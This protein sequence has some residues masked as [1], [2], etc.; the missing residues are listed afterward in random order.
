MPR[1]RRIDLLFNFPQTEEVAEEIG[2]AVRSARRSYGLPEVPTRICDPVLS[3]GH[4]PENPFACTHNALELSPTRL[5]P[6]TRGNL[7]P[8]VFVT[9]YEKTVAEAQTDL[10]SLHLEP[11]V[12]VSGPCTF[13]ERK[14][15]RIASLIVE[16]PT[17]RCVNHCSDTRRSITHL[18][19]SVVEVETCA[20]EVAR[21]P[22]GSCPLRSGMDPVISRYVLHGEYPI[23]RHP[24][25][26][27]TPK[28]SLTV[29]REQHDA[30]NDVTFAFSIA[31]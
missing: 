29:R 2:L 30:G 16:S 13:E 27:E 9:V 19:L 6:A 5:G 12:L 31:Q 25:E 8:G 21:V 4:S 17:C 3:Q 11:R 15:L 7:D 14:R 1:H 24:A 10:E 22:V 20:E 23:E 26:M 28:P 18:A